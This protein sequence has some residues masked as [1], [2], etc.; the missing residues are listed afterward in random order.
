MKSRPD[1][2]NAKTADPK[3]RTLKL[4]EHFTLG[5]F[6]NICRS[7]FE[8]EMKIYIMELNKTQVNFFLR[9]EAPLVETEFINMKMLQIQ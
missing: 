3:E 2:Y 7:L 6:A 9:C 1:G 4:N 8:K 5:M